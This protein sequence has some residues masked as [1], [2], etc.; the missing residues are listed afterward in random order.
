MQGIYHN[1]PEICRDKIWSVVK[2]LE[3]FEM[4]DEIH[5]LVMERQTWMLM[6]Y[7]MSA[8]VAWHLY[9]SG[10][11]VPK[12]SYPSAALEVRATKCN[13]L[14]EKKKKKK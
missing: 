3:W 11:Q 14:R 5:T 10:T 13:S 6:P 8:F 2:S 9:L 7:T 12:V 1:Y 4:Y